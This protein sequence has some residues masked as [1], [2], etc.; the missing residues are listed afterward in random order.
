MKGASILALEA[1]P[2]S[3]EAVDAFFATQKF[4]IVE[5]NFITFV[6][7]GEA[8]AVH[9]KHWVFGLPSSQ[10]LARVEKTDVWYLTLQLPPGSRVEY[11][12]EVVRNGHGEWMQ[13]P[14]N[15]NTARDPF[16]G[17]S[18]AHGTGYE[19]PSWIHPDPTAAKGHRD[20]IWID[21]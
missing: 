11:K 6:W 3:R 14:L 13:D 8:E 18:V 7:R 2:R 16:G 9:L 20:E 5:G 17:N 21:S 15:Q 4:P 19:I 12:L 1:G 10:Q